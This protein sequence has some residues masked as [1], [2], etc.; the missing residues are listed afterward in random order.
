M[1]I[2]SEWLCNPEQET[3]VTFPTGEEREG[4]NQIL[5]LALRDGRVQP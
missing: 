5:K 1:K 4:Y 2:N 3:T